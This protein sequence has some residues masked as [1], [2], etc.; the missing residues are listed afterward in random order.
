[1]ANFLCLRNMSRAFEIDDIPETML[2]LDHATTRSGHFPISQGL[3]ISLLRF[4]FSSSLSLVEISQ[5]QHS[6]WAT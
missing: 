4:S 1:M 6:Q 2:S 3:Q 5:Q